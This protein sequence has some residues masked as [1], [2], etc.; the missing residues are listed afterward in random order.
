[1]PPAPQASVPAGGSGKTLALVGVIALL[2]MVITIG[3]AVY[4]LTSSSSPEE[5]VAIADP[6]AAVPATADPGTAAPA[7][8]ATSAPSSTLPPTTQPPVQPP[9]AEEALLAQLPAGWVYRLDVDQPA[10]KEFWAGEANSEWTSVYVVESDVAGAWSVTDIQPWI[11]GSDVPVSAE[12]EAV[13][14]VGDFLYA[15]QEDRPSDAQ[16]LTVDPLRSDPASAM[17]TNGEF[18][19]FEVLGAEADPDGTFWVTVKEKW[20]YGTEIW[21][22]WV[23]STEAGWRVADMAPAG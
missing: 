23:V 15:L 19:S 13:F 21:R 8:P 18:L 6:T 1:M 10:H 22:Y 5:D 12:E 16:A 11:G 2:A 9:T 4:L 7:A 17:Y 3:G 20:V 14:V